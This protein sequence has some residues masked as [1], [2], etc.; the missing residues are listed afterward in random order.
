MSK[1]KL[2]P[3]SE[4]VSWLQQLIEKDELL[5]SIQGQEAITSLIDVVDQEYFIPSFGIDYIS[6]R[7]SAEAAG[8]VLRRL[9]LLDIVSINTSI[10]LTTGEV[11]RPDI[12]CFNPETKTLVV[13]EVKRASETER[14]TVTEL[15]GYEQELR[16]MLPFLGHFD[17]C[18]VVVAADWSTLLVHAVGSMNAWSAKQCLALKLTSDESGFGL[19]AHL[20]EAWHLTGSTNLPP[21]ALT[22][23]D[24]YLVHK[25]IDELGDELGSTDSDEGFDDERWPP[26]V[27]LTAMDVIA[28]A[29]D[30]AGS[31][32]FMMLWR[33]VNGYGRGR[34]CVTLTAI[35][36]YAMHVWCR[37]HGL[38][39]RESEA[40]TFLH[41]RRNDLLG[42]TPT[43]VYDIAKAAF[44]LLEK[45]FDPEF[46]G[47]FHWQMKTRQYRL[48]G[49]PTRFDFWGS[50]GQHAREFV[51]NP[52]VRN[53]YMSFVGANQL[54]WTDPAVAMT[55]VA[56]LSL[57][58]P[59]PGGVIKCSDAFLAGRV[60]G[61]LAVA[62]FSASPDKEHAA[63]IEPMVEWAQL[64]ALR[65]AIEMKQMYDI[66]EEVVARMPYL[67]NDP[68]KRFDST[69]EL[70]QWVRKDLISQ[71]H[72]FHQA[73]FDL[74]YRHSLLFNLLDE[75][76]TKHLK[77][78]ESGGAAEIVRSILT[79][80]LVRAE[81]S[82]GHVLHTEKFLRFMAFLEPHLRP[83]MGLEDESS[84]S[85]VV[86]AIEDEVLLS[87]FPDYIVGGV[88]SII[89]VVL[90]TTRPPFPGKVDW[91]WLKA[92]VK[93]LYESGDHCPAVIF[94]QDG[95]VGTG[96][97]QEPFRMVSPISDPEEEVYVIDE[98]SAL[99][100][101]IKKTWDGVKEFHAKRSQGYSQPPSDAAR[102]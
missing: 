53:N 23:I 29:G 51:C 12:L 9:G 56:N 38:P 57:G 95:M 76:G 75:G 19:V 49:V 55:L 89:P 3:E 20:P 68:A 25:G 32:G 84:V 27:V 91:E 42:Q 81:G 36:P 17:V 45:H 65:F 72:L 63:K 54:D 64:E 18:F 24:L 101:A 102:G 85:G 58:V 74:G 92:G 30:R 47:D 22:S 40:A 15:A 87:G 26:R 78:D 1:A 66:T 96:R 100:I 44:P 41:N 71:R 62:A 61:D 8:H 16:N 35:D 31:H 93:A 37:E 67:S 88:D 39:Q 70:A 7:A 43:T 14:Q 46:C 90:H 59:F 48:R 60:L 99:S 97:L 50:L 69:Q 13:F 98:S 11:L 28:R 52:A 82:Q 86:D 80:V 4:V 34:W 83:G 21:E 77:S 2:P 33:D 79:A 5:E 94:S 73:C 6:R 10:S